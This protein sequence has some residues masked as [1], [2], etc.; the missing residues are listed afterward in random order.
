MPPTPSRWQ[1][2]RRTGH[3]GWRL[4]PL[5]RLRQRLTDGL[6]VAAAT[7][8][9]RR[10]EEL[11]ATVTIADPEGLGDIEVGI[12]CTEL[13]DEEVWTGGEHAGNSRTTSSATAHETW[14]P[15][16]AIAGTQSVRL[17]IPREAP[18]SY[19]GSCLSFE[20]ELVARGRR[21]RKLDAQATDA[22]RVLP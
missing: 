19:D 20:W 13:Y 7:H 15:V 6:E 12:V 9:V 14:V 16:E 21:E 2:F 17:A 3:V 22:I 4:N 5:D 10:G 11:E 18:F 8:E 1:K